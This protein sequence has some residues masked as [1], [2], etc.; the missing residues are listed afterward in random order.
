MSTTSASGPPTVENRPFRRRPFA[1]IA[2]AEGTRLLRHPAFLVGLAVSLAAP[3]L[4]S[5]PEAWPGQHYYET[6]VAWTF[7]WV[8]TVVAAALVAGRERIVSDT[9]LFPGTPTP[10]GARVL[11]TALGLVGPAVATAAAVTAVAAVTVSNG[12]FVHGGGGYARRITPH[13]FE[14]LQPVLL[15]I[16]AGVVGIAIAQLRRARLATLLAVAILTFF[17]GSAIWAFQAHPVRVLH[18]LMYPAYEVR[19]ADSFTP[20]GWGPASPPLTPPD[21]DFSAWRETRFDTAALG[22]HLIFL[23]GLVLI[24]LSLAIRMAD[25]GE[26]PARL[27]V[28]VA[29]AALALLGGVAQV[30]TAGVAS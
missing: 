4:N 30:L 16:L 25:R 14:W 23:G 11:G 1:A 9:E 28:V 5:G 21:Q 22:W 6:T 8:G 29:G 2:R 12:G 3:R 27:W 19:L 13:L 20:D 26:H 15:V 10:P 17:G 24:S 18:P 7:V